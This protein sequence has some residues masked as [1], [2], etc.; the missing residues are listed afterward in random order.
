MI[1]VPPFFYLLIKYCY[2]FIG[3]Y[4]R[5]LEKGTQNESRFHDTKDCQSDDDGDDMEDDENSL[6]KL[7]KYVEKKI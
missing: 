6:Q 5:Q 1:S 7:E 4:L 2:I 3:T